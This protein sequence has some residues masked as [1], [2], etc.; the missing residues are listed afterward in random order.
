[1]DVR[2]DAGAGLRAR[3][4]DLAGVSPRAQVRKRLHPNVRLERRVDRPAHE[5]ERLDAELAQQE[6]RQRSCRHARRGLARA[7]ALERAAAVDGR[8]LQ[9]SGE[10]GMPGARAVHR[11][12]LLQVIQPAV[13]VLHLEHDGRAERHALPHAG[14]HAHLVML[15]PL[16][17]AAPIARLPTRQFRIDE[18]RVHPQAGGQPLDEGEHRRAMRFAGRAVGEHRAR[19]I[20]RAVSRPASARTAGAP[21][22]RTSASHRPCARRANAIRAGAASR[23]A[24]TRCPSP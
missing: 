15:D 18:G 11:R 10:V 20:G 16:P 21:A 8:P 22:V 3:A 23:A 24:R 1:M 4:R 13:G 14:Q 12:R 6:P 2:H 17:R 9:A 7:R 5:A 19:R